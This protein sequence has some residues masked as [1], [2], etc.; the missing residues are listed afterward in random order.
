[1]TP[2]ELTKVFKA[3]SAEWF[4]CDSCYSNAVHSVARNFNYVVIDVWEPT[5]K[6]S[7]DSE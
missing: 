5:F 6:E 3:I 4:H 7:G 2:A 1:M